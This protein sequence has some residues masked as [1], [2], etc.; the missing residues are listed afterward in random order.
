M[1]TDGHPAPADWASPLARIAAGDAEAETMLVQHFLPRVRALLMARTRNAD[2]AR[3]LTQDALLALLQAA[4]RQ[5]IRDPERLPA[6]VA[7]IARNLANSHLRGQAARERPLDV[8]VH[9]P[10]VVDDHDRR[11][12]E[13]L[14]T[15]GL[16]ALTPG[17]REVLELTLLEGLKPA[18]IA[19]RLGL[20]AEVVR[21]RKS[22]AQQRLHEALPAVSRTDRP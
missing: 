21:T 8:L 11:E 16:A 18:E 5:Q 6:F 10:F 22:R 13:R 14:L 1:T 3:D 7:G 2:L 17:D 4:R 9:E 15:Q 20:S 19:A 12:R